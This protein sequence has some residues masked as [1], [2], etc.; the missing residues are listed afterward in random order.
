MIQ[1]TGPSE[2]IS[3]RKGDSTFG[4]YSSVLWVPKRSSAP[5]TS[6]GAVP[7]GARQPHSPSAVRSRFA[8]TAPIGDTT[9]RHRSKDPADSLGTRLA[10]PGKREGGR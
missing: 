5:S 3:K 10:N 9:T 2:C 8:S 7:G 4:E 6:T 1:A